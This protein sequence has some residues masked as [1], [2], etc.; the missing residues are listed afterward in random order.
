MWSYNPF[1]LRSLLL[2][3]VVVVGGYLA[4]KD[5]G[6]VSGG[7]RWIQSVAF[8]QDGRTLV[9][10]VDHY[11]VVW[12]AETG[13]LRCSVNYSPRYPGFTLGSQM[14][15]APSGTK[16]SVDSYALGAVIIDTASCGRIATLDGRLPGASPV[17]AGGAVGASF[18]PDE[19]HVVAA[20]V[21][22]A[23]AAE[24]PLHLYDAATGE[25]LRSFRTDL[26]GD[27]KKMDASATSPD[28]TLVAVGG[29]GRIGPEAYGGLAIVWDLQSGEQLYHV[30]EPSPGVASVEFSPDGE[31]LLVRGVD[32][33]VRL[34][35]A[36]RGGEAALLRTTCTPVDA[37]AFLPPADTVLAGCDSGTVEAC[38][39][40]TGNCA[41][42]ALPGVNRLTALAVHP[43]GDRVAIAG[44]GGSITVADLRSGDRVR[45][46]DVPRSAPDKGQFGPGPP[47]TPP[48][49]V[50]KSILMGIGPLLWAG[51]LIALLVWLQV[52]KAWLEPGTD[53]VRRTAYIGLRTGTWLT[54]GGLIV[55]FL[56]FIPAGP[57]MV[58]VL[59]PV[60]YAT[61]SAFLL[62]TALGLIIGAW[63]NRDR[64]NGSQFVATLG[65]ILLLIALGTASLIVALRW[66][67]EPK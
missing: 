1:S 57:W 52:K 34:W 50:F 59:F 19:G 51:G 28:G 36:N 10:D 8:S 49:E 47:R 40:R 30:T 60:A 4:I 56:S 16:V 42:T 20:D 31:R 37:T 32:G 61:P 14:S 66:I 3:A 26:A 62:S 18:G 38:D 39:V 22:R 67:N 53:P 54:L 29:A 35:D 43:D 6:Q 11:L 45:V 21:A 27:I 25:R 46:I 5:S 63:T 17:F 24:A 13:Q 2:I 15:L 12:D 65:V 33:A 64:L 7:G 48:L 23:Y 58:F 55:L 9:A 41:P 44:Q